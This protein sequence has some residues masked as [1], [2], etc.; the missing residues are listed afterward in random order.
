MNFK[1][2]N[3]SDVYL[4]NK[5]LGTMKEGKTTF[6]YF[7]NRSL[8]VIKNHL[9]TV[10]L[11]NDNLPIAY[12]HL[13]KEDNDVWL[14][15]AVSDNYRGKGYGEKMLKYLIK[16]AKVKNIQ[17]IKLSVDNNNIP[18]INLYKKY[19]FIEY[20]EDMVKK[21]YYLILEL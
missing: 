9:I 16:Y 11:V 7:E 4:I 19:G 10:L 17:Q 14:G 18:A 6:R 2:I 15:I 13:D 8:E 5:F 12:G 20:K 21:N 1:K 3:F